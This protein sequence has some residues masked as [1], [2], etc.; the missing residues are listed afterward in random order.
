MST[1]D[2]QDWLRVEQW[3][4]SP[5]V[6]TDD[7]I[8]NN[9]DTFGP[10][11]VA[12]WEAI[13]FQTFVHAPSALS[14]HGLIIEFSDPAFPGVVIA[15]LV[16]RALAGQIINDIVPVQGS[17]MT[18]KVDSLPAAKHMSLRVVPRRGFNATSRLWS[19]EPLA[20]GANLPVAA[21]VGITQLPVIVMAAHCTWSVFTDAVAWGATLQY[22]DLAS[23]VQGIV[24]SSG[25]TPGDGLATQTVD[26][27]PGPVRFSFVNLDAVGRTVFWALTPQ[28]V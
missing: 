13:A 14:V 6:A 25:S 24:G 5:F 18:V 4:G 2:Y 12:P 22:L 15:Q 9:N 28:H 7:Q 23:G 10:F 20:I 26:L 16:Y 17:M 1:S 3:V 27:P 21:G 19:G 8:V 11:Y